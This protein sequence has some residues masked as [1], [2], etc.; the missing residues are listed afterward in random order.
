MS[1]R[2]R[3]FDTNAPGGRAVVT[4]YG[5]TD[6][7]AD[8]VQS[9]GAS[10]DILANFVVTTPTYQAFAWTYPGAK[11]PYKAIRLEAAGARWG[12]DPTG[13]AEAWEWDDLDV[14][15]APINRVFIDDVSVG[16]SMAA[17]GVDTEIVAS[18]G[19]KL[20]SVP[21]EWFAEVAGWT[22]EQIR[23]QL[24]GARSILEKPGRAANGRLSLAEC[25]VLGIDPNDPDQDFVI[26][27]FPL[28]VDGTP[29]LAN[30]KFEPSPEKWKIKNLTF[31]LRGAAN[32]AGEWF[33]V[34]TGGDSTFRFFKVEVV[35]P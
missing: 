13:R 12:R 15:Q 6:P 11:S 16:E 31:K 28:K 14:K 20:V 22:V 34:P 2:A 32:L 9:D 35:L 25:Y 18:I 27:E 7:N 17:L 26:T 10:W 5:G 33:D 30:I 1:F 3:L 24:D 21:V 4:L 8:Q 23:A 19:G 29:D